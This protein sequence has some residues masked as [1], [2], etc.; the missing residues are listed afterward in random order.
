MFDEPK[1]ILSWIQRLKIMRGVTTR[2][3]YLHKEWEQVVIHHD[4]KARMADER[5]MGQRDGWTRWRWALDE[6]RWVRD[7]EGGICREMREM[8]AG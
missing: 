3:L 5:E 8:D 7:Q 4:V 2:L 1:A 6:A